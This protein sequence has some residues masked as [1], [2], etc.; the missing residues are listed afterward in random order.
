MWPCIKGDDADAVVVLQLLDDGHSGLDCVSELLAVALS[1][2]TR[3][4]K[5]MLFE[6]SMTMNKR[7]RLTFSRARASPRFERYRKH[8]CPACYPGATCHRKWLRR[9][10]R[11]VRRR[12]LRTKA[13]ECFEVDWP[14]SCAPRMSSRTTRSLSAKSS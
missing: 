12:R 14:F 8:L 2:P 4:L 10:R 3:L 7:H 1:V 6:R 5:P 9:R 13:L 11:S